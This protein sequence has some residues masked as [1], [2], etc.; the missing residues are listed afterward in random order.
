MVFARSSFMVLFEIHLGNKIVN[1]YEI[2][3]DATYLYTEKSTDSF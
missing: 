2:V 3:M 1:V